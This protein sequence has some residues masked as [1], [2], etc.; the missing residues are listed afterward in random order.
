MNKYNNMVKYDITLFQE[1]AVNKDDE[2]N[3]FITNLNKTLNNLNKLL[4]LNTYKTKRL[5]KISS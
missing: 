3:I 1:Y 4:N 2:N 5:D